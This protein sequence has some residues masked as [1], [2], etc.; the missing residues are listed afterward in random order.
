MEA[1]FSWETG[2]PAEMEASFSWETGSPAEPP[3]DFSWR[4]GLP[5]EQLA[6]EQLADQSANC[7]D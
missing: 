6:S 3:F 4:T 2:S 5:A 1:S 7:P